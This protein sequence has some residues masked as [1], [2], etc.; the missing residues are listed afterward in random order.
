MRVVKIILLIITLSLLNTNVFGDV[1]EKKDCSK[2][3]PGIKNLYKK[4]ICKTGNVTSVI[5]EKKSV[6]DFF[7]KK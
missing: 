2:I 3:E 7:K 4:I 5:T 1:T 6:A